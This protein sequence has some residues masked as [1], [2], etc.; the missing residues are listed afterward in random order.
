MKFVRIRHQKKYL[1]FCTNFTDRSE[2][3]HLPCKVND[4]YSLEAVFKKWDKNKY[5]IVRYDCQK[6]KPLRIVS[7]VI[8]GKD[9]IRGKDLLLYEYLPSMNFSVVKNGFNSYKEASEA[10][11]RMK[12]NERN[13][14]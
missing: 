6:N 7:Y 4:L 1:N 10:L 14:I 13:I 2:W 12:E 9:L 8:K 3:V 5:A 11:E